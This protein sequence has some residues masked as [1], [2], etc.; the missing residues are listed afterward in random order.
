MRNTSKYNKI[1][2]SMLIA[3][4]ALLAPKVQANN[5]LK[6]MDAVPIPNERTI[7]NSSALVDKRLL[8]TT[9]FD[10]REELTVR[11]KDQKTTN[12]CWTFASNTVLETN[13]LLTKNQQYDFSE[14][15]MEYATSKT[16]SD[17]TNTLGHNRELNAG[18]NASIAMGYYVSGRGPVLETEM[19]F[20]TTQQQI[21]LSDI[22]GKTVQK[23]ITDYAIFPEILKTKDESGNI[24]YTKKPTTKSPTGITMSPTTNFQ[25]ML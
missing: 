20:S 23:K 24:T 15:H 17:G 5:E 3:S 21:A 4:Y 2:L 12:T 7:I 10:L 13:L 18:G 6:I 1:F 22:Q 14:R 8:A 9:S 16:F 11:V 19:P 25:S